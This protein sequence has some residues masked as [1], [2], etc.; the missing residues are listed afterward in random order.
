MDLSIVHE[1]QLFIFSSYIFSSLHKIASTS[2]N[3]TSQ[4]SAIIQ[5][6]AIQLAMSSSSAIWSALHDQLI[7][8]P[9]LN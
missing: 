2:C 4:E 5:Y 1:L 8:I 6:I 7:K 3:K 9:E